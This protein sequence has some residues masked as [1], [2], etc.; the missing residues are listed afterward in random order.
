MI[1]LSLSLSLSLSVS[2]YLSLFVSLSL[3]PCL[4]LSLSL[5]LSLFVD[6][7]VNKP[8]EEAI[9]IYV[10]ALRQVF[11]VMPPPHRRKVFPFKHIPL[12]SFPFFSLV[13]TLTALPHLDWFFL[14]IGSSDIIRGVQQPVL[15]SARLDHSSKKGCCQQGVSIFC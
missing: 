13:I 2:L 5:S 8:A 3:C 10:S 15:C 12:Y 4:C 1:S 7:N 6:V 14:Y 11:P 9:L